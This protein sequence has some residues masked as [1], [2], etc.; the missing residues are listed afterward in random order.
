MGYHLLS[1]ENFENEIEPKKV[2]HIKRKLL[3]E[4]NND[5][6]KVLSFNTKLNDSEQSFAENLK[7]MY[8]TGS[9]TNSQRKNTYRYVINAPEKILDAPDFK[10]DFYLNLLDW[11]T[12]NNLAVALNQDLYIWNATTKEISQLFGMDESQP[13]YI[14][15]VSWIQKGNVLA[16]GNSK[17][18]IQLWDV[19]KKCVI[20]TLKSHVSRVGSL[21][22]NSHVLSSGS[23]SGDIHHHDVRVAKHHIGSSKHHRQEVCGLKWSPDGKYLL[24]GANDNLCCVWDSGY[25]LESPNPLHVLRDHT[26]AVK[27]VSWCPWQSNI[28]STGG[29]TADGKI[30]IWNVYNGNIV[31]SVE[32]KSQV[33]SILWSKYHKEMI[34][35]HGHE[36]NQ[37]SIWKYSDMSKVCDLTGHTNRVLKMAMSPDEETVAS[38]GADETLR[39]WKCFAHDDKKKG[40]DASLCDKSQSSFA[41]CIR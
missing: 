19:N 40:K 11:S 23:R 3:S 10:D 13:D 35:A 12:S 1:K 4:L 38:I 29:G 24:S 33:S 22:W 25:S 34:S 5:K 18:L 32:T 7:L 27:A 17:H 9:V 37:L 16:V 39:L 20:R 14:T 2:D 8:S 41:R 15:S 36:N 30:N 21:S 6:E 31:Q 26:A 28:L